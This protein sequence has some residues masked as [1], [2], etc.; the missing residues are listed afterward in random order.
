LIYGEEA[1]Q[2]RKGA[3]I[4]NKKSIVQMKKSFEL[5]SDKFLGCNCSDETSKKYG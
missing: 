4:T 3:Q 1:A 2:A 5:T